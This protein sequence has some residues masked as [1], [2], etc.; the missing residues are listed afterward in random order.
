M[1]IPLASCMWSMVSSRLRWRGISFVMLR[2]M[3]W[4]WLVDI[5]TPGMMMKFFG[6]F[7]SA[8]SEPCMV[9]WS[10]MLT[11]CNPFFWS[12]F[13]YCFICGC[14]PDTPVAG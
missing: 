7:C 4:L 12:I 8:C 1:G 14:V 13:S 9:L 5:S 2:A 3:R 6:G 10:V 11:P